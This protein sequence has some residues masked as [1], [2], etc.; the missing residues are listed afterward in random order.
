MARMTTLT[1]ALSK[2][3]GGVNCCS[4]ESRN[5]IGGLTFNR[6]NKLPAPV[7]IADLFNC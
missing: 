6:R 1:E 2:W 4:I 7:K 5:V 3:I